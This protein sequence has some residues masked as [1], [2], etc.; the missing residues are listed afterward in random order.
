MMQAP[1][2]GNREDHARFRRL[3][4]PS[5]RGVLVEREVRPSAMIVRGQDAAQMPLAEHDDYKAELALLGYDVAELTVAKYMHRVSRRPSPT[6]RTFL[7][8]HAPDIVASAFF[9]VPT[10]PFRLLFAFV[11]LRHQRRELVHF[12]ITEHP[13]AAWTARQ[14]V[15]AFPG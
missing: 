6:W 4:G 10:L 13:T 1:D 14:L 8:T 2:F 7:T 15:E 12:N 9:V 11:V 3:D 5:V